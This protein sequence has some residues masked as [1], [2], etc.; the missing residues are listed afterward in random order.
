MSPSRSHSD[1]PHP[2][3]FADIITYGRLIGIINGYDLLFFYK[4]LRICDEAYL[5]HHKPVTVTKVNE[6]I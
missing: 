2:L 5:N 3:K 4:M 6:D 1:T